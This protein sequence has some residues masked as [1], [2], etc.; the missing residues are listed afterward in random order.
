MKREIIPVNNPSLRKKSKRVKKIDKKIL[1]LIDDLKDTLTAQKDPE[2]IGLAA[3]QIGKNLQVFVMRFNDK[4]KVIINPRVL[5]VSKQK[6]KSKKKGG[7]KIMEGCLSIPNYYGYVTRAFKIKIKYL[8]PNGK[9]KIETFSGTPAQI[10]QHEIDH[11]KGLLFVDRLLEQKQ[12]L[13]E[14]ID[15][16]W[17]KVDLIL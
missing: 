2:G 4:L 3:P 17:E 11:L 15:G 12:Y 14:C 9:E 6:I 5:E 8:S 1:A 13:Y 16:E 10:V 7:R